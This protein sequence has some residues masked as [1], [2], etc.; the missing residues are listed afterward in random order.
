[1]SVIVLF[2]GLFVFPLVGVVGPEKGVMHDPIQGL[3]L[4]FVTFATL[5]YGN[6]TPHGVLGEI[7]GG[8]EAL[9]GALLTS[10]FL[11]ALATRYVHRA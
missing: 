10:M 1:M 2:F 7:F 8:I 4:S 9:M 3:A 5:G 11:V 6:R